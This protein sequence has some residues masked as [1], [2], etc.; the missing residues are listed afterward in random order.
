MLFY[1]ILNFRLTGNE[2]KIGGF[3]L[4]CRGHP[5]KFNE[6]LTFG[7]YL[8][9]YNKREKQLKS[10]SKNI[11]SKLNQIHLHKNMNNLNISTNIP[12]KR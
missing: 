5:I 8:G 7:T 6:N 4:I 10:L 3:D 9:C 11:A 12:N 2:D 1:T